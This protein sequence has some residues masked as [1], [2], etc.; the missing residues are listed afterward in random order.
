MTEITFRSEVSEGPRLHLCATLAVPPSYWD[1]QGASFQPLDPDDV[2]SD[3]FAEAWLADTRYGLVAHDL[4]SE[5]VS[6]LAV[7][8]D[9]QPES[10]HVERFL[11]A[12][13][14]GPE[15]LLEIFGS[16]PSLVAAGDREIL[17]VSR[18]LAVRRDAGL[19]V[20]LVGSA[21]LSALSLVLA[22]DLS[23]WLLGVAIFPACAAVV[24]LLVGEQGD[25]VFGRRIEAS[26][27]ESAKV[28]MA[29]ESTEATREADRWQ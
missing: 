28:P 27:R 19:V 8:S 12:S 24:F 20:A 11:K 3:L 13:R 26:A 25:G 10:W 7:P 29:S 1:N 4:E 9:G 6:L 21:L 17:S 14:L 16:R 5:S 23:L 15:A 18:N 22:F 2:T